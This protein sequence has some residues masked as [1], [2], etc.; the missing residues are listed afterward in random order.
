MIKFKIEKFHWILILHRA[1]VLKKNSSIYFLENR[2]T[3]IHDIPDVMFI[4]MNQHF[5]KRS[6]DP[7]CRLARFL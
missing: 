3:D 2:A 7:D 6:H 1:T 4:L 5:L